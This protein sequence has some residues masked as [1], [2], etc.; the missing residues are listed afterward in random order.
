MVNK[1]ASPMWASLAQVNGAKGDPNRAE[2]HSN[3]VCLQYSLKT[4][5]P[6]SECGKEPVLRFGFLTLAAWEAMRALL[7]LLWG[8]CKSA[9]SI[10]NLHG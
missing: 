6:S 7:C 5:I 2:S 3:C 9:L 1:C 10:L 8:R 4:V